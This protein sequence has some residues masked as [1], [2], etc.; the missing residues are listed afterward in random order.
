M[1][2]VVV[3]AVARRVMMLGAVRMAVF[4]ALFKQPQ[5]AGLHC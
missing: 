5:T 4:V 2:C 3:M 1:V